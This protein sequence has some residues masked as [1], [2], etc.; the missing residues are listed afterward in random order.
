MVPAVADADQEL[1]QEIK[2]GLSNAGADGNDQDFLTN[3]QKYWAA[4]DQ[5]DEQGESADQE[6]TNDE[7]AVIIQTEDASDEFYFDR[8]DDGGNDNNNMLQ[9]SRNEYICTHFPILNT[10]ECLQYLNICCIIKE[11]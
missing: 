10:N 9:G 2:E 3:D 1:Y 5:G 7:E 8:V 6:E 4:A 11:K